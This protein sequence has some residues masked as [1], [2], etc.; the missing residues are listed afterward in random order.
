M[1]SFAVVHVQGSRARGTGFTVAK[2]KPPHAGFGDEP[3]GL[4]KL[5]WTVRQ[6]AALWGALPSLLLLQRSNSSVTAV[7]TSRGLVIR[8]PGDF[9]EQ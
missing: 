3:C 7:S 4:A 2:R 5:C 8:L 6:T 1:S 9:P